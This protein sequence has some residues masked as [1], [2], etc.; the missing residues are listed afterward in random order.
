MELVS[1]SLCVAVFSCTII[2]SVLS[3][4]LFQLFWDLGLLI[5]ELSFEAKNLFTSRHFIDWEGADMLSVPR[6]TRC[7]KRYMRGPLAELF[8]E[9]FGVVTIRVWE[10]F[11]WKW[12]C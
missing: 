11:A 2:F 5:F 8:E 12:L 4:L 10:V 3:S 7:R 9:K 6:N 1:L